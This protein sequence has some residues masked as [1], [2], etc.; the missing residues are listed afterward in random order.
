MICPVCDGTG[1]EIIKTSDT[2][3]KFPC[4]ECGQTGFANCCEGL[5]SQPEED[6]YNGK[7]NHK[8]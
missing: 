8:G 7:V 6:E 4:S 2:I 5:C 1:W 3:C